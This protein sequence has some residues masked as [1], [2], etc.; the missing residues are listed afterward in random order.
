VGKNGEFAQC[1]E[2]QFFDI[3]GKHLNPSVRKGWSTRCR[4]IHRDQTEMSEIQ[5]S[6]QYH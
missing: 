1:K 4:G 3:A 5:N 6:D 2:R